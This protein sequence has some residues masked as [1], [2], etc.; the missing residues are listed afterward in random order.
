MTQEQL[1]DVL[2]MIDD[3][4]IE[5]VDKLRQQRDSLATASSF[6]HFDT[7]NHAANLLHIRS[8]QKN[9]LKWGG[10]AACICLLIGV[11]FFW[12]TGGSTTAD[13][14]RDFDN[15][16][17]KQENADAIQEEIPKTPQENTSPETLFQETSTDLSSPPELYLMAQNEQIPSHIGSYRWHWIN[18]DDVTQSIE[19]D[20]CHP[21]LLQD[22]LPVILTSGAYLTLQFCSTTI[23]P[24]ELHVQCWSDRHWND[25]TAE[26]QTIT[27]VNDTIPLQEGGY[28][29]EI[30]AKWN[31]GTVRYSFYA[32][33]TPDPS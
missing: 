14:K 3:D 2:G 6:R 8:L 22:S 30:T 29:Y 17:S 19:A 5:S 12:L 24:Y 25:I 31:Q 28:I 7:S 10:L 13:S 33:Y 32:V 18:S 23:M 15:L 9:I 1:Q 16:F 4:L 26:A 20:S 27:P 21:L 11:R